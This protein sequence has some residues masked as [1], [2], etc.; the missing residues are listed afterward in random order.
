MYSPAKWLI[1]ACYIFAA[2]VTPA[3]AQPVKG[4]TPSKQVNQTPPPNFIF[5]LGE[6]HGW[7]S[8]SV[9]M[10]DRIGGSSQPDGLTPNLEKLAASGMRFSD[11]Y[12]TCPRCT[13]SRASFFTGISPAKLH[14]TYVND[15]GG[16]G[17]GA[18]RTGG[19][20]RRKPGEPADA[21]K[22]PPAATAP[23]LQRMNPPTPELEL[24]AGVQTTGDTLKEAG[25]AT[26]HFG[27]WHVGRVSPSRHGFDETD[28]ANTNAGPGNNRTPNPGES[29][30]ITDR[31]IAFIEAQVKAGKPFFL[32]LSHYGAGTEE[33]VTP[34]SLAEAK[35]L[36]PN[37]KGKMLASAAGMRDMDKAIGRVMQ[38]IAELGIADNTYIIFSTDHGSPGGGGGGGGG[39]RGGPGSEANA[40][41]S[42]G[43]GSV[44]EGGVRIPFIASGPGIRAGSSSHVRA[45]GMDLLP[46]LADLAGHPIHVEASHRDDRN[47]VEGG[48]LV[49]VLKGG[50]GGVK[51]PRQEIVIHF[52]HYDLGNGGPASAIYLGD[53][54]LLRVDETGNRLLFDVSKDCAEK[55]DLAGKMPDKVK[56][57]E[58][59]LDAYLDAV[60]AQK[61][62]VNPAFKDDAPPATTPDRK[63]RDG[64]KG[65][66]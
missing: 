20:G 4:V 1:S 64:G 12:A 55:N 9:Q 29:K 13:P 62:T 56:E 48:S 40:P 16:A 3:S 66:G 35:A 28:G 57:L 23:L 14:M 53:Y 61:A 54:K 27:K 63:K 46:T 37:L 10:D 60:H 32:Q 39:G 6:G 26:A 31:G 22:R 42:R 2:L 44:Q 38:R 7:S 30:A 49:P 17:E 34:E 24:P 47:V 50:T 5:I 36:L 51:R 8:T 25:Y 15:K 41:L 18:D 59:A 19:G 65:G 11:F 43:K 52:P 21:D 45:T 33:E 58:A